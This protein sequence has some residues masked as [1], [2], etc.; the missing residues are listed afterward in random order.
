LQEIKVKVMYFQMPLV[1]NA[2]EEYFVLQSPAY[3]RDLLAN[4]LQE[5]PA[6]SP[7]TSSMLI[8]VDGVHA[9]PTTVLRD[10]DEVDLIPA[11]AG[12]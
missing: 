4:I 3:F 10:G 6:L 8:L 2:R 12:G 1:L 9:Q 7:M 5:H 11:V